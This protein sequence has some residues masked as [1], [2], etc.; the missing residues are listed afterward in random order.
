MALVRPKVS[1]LVASQLPEH[2]RNE[3]PQFVA[4]LEAYYKFL[5]QNEIN[6]TTAR[7]LDNTLD[8]FVFNFKNE[9]GQNLPYTQ[10]DERF[11]LKH[12]KDLYLA[13]GSEASYD[14][15]FKILFGKKVTLDYPSKQMLRAS[16]GKWN[17]DISVFVKINEGDPDTIVGKLVDVITPNRIIRVLIDRRQYVEV[18]VERAIK[19]S[20]DVYELILDRRFFGDIN[21]GDRLRYRNDDTAN[22]FSG[23]ILAT[24]SSLEIQAKGTG[25][26]VGEL[27]DIRNFDGYGTIMKVK[28][29]D[30]DG[31]INA[32]EFIKYGIGYS[33]EFTSTL[34]PKAGQ[35]EQ[36]K[37]GTSV[38]RVLN[39]LRIQD[40]MGG[41]SEVGTVN[42]QT[43]FDTNDVDG[44]YADGTYAGEVQREFG[45]TTTDSAVSDQDPAII[46]VGLGAIA[47]YPGYY[48]NNDGFLD[49]AIYIQDSRYYQA[50][51]YL[52]KIDETLDSY[53]SAVKTLIHP[54]GM[55]LFGEYDIRNEFDISVQLESLIKILTVSAEDEILATEEQVF[56]GGVY[57]SGTNSFRPAVVGD[58]PAHAGVQKYVNDTA[59]YAPR[60]ELS[61]SSDDNTF[62]LVDTAGSNT[63]RTNPDYSL[64]KA[65]YNG[66]LDYDGNAADHTFSLESHPLG[67]N[68]DLNAHTD[69]FKDV[70]KR[71]DKT[72]TNLN[73]SIDHE[74][75]YMLSSDLTTT[76]NLFS[77][78]TDVSFD[79]SKPLSTNYGGITELPQTRMAT[80][81]FRFGLSVIDMEKE[82]NDVP[83]M[84][85]SLTYAL[86]M[87]VFTDSTSETDIT[88]IL[89]SK[90]ITSTS[91]NF[92]GSVDNETVSIT[93]DKTFEINKPLSDSQTVTENA[94][95]TMA[96]GLARFGLS[97]I[98]SDKVLTTSYS[99]MVDTDAP[100][101]ANQLNRTT[102]ALDFAMVIDEGVADAV[103]FTESGFINKNP[104]AEAGFFLNDDGIYVSDNYQ[105]I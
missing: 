69:Q 62:F 86:T 6:L 36:A 100:A 90:N 95:A 52:I 57:D 59:L 22:Y 68:G 78:T 58:D 33:T 65:L 66:E 10:V 41:F 48:I 32:A 43:Y 3:Q 55:A 2:I 102:P 30:N 50:Y 71:I 21:V 15:L 16:D 101:G 26:K 5:E 96:N 60:V 74:S 105:T 19:I 23:D 83:V 44:I 98:D 9:L 84:S 76:G 82:L 49:D 81:V 39:E 45:I 93:E 54:A 73:G 13:K 7:D 1:N 27:Y 77:G 29:V 75:V 72:S 79:M 35:A 31:G 14:L 56:D 38:L 94:E 20:D 8:Q 91:T 87:D 37:A 12:I 34:I 24:T 47:N 67:V 53:Q 42:Y 92:D 11:L 97:A 64:S 80:G 18:E 4:F 70:A 85:E 103:S 104:F 89:T 40:R 25:F 63:T 99:G 46:K 88:T 17:Q 61:T 51:S 28:S